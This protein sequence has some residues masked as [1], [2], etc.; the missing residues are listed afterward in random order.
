MATR[1]I[2]GKLSYDPSENNKIIGRN[3]FG[4]VFNGSFHYFDY[5]GSITRLGKSVAVKRILKN[6][7]LDHFDEAIVTLEQLRKVGHP[8]ILRYICAEVDKNFM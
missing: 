4:T 3:S 6:R 1:V 7:L 8:N 5:L 2:L